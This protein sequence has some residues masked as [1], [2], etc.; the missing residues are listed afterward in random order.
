MDFNHIYHKIVK[1]ESFKYF[2]NCST[3]QVKNK[4]TLSM[5]DATYDYHVEI[6]RSY[7]DTLI[8][9]VRNSDHVVIYKFKKINVV[10]QE[11]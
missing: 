10:E 2:G 7:L 4:W 5:H 6:N 1:V 8:L 9:G 11:Y 3:V